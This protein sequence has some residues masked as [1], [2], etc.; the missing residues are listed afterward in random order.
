MANTIYSPRLNPIKYYKIDPGQLPQ[1]LSK[2]FDD[3]QFKNTIRDFEQP[4]DFYQPWIFEDSIRQQFISNFK[5]LTL[6]L[7]NCKGKVIYETPFQNMQQH[8]RLPDFYIRQSELDLGSLT[9]LEEGLYYFKI[10]ELDWISEPQE[11]LEYHPNTVYA[12]YSSSDNYYEGVIF[13]SPIVMSLRIPSILKYKSPGSVD[14]IY[15]DQNEAETML[16]SVPFR[17]WRFIVGGIGG[18]PP[19]FI[20][21]VARITGCDNLK[22]DGRQYTKA[23][24]A[25][26]EE[27]GL[28][29]YPM[30]GWAIDLRELL[31]RNSDVEEND[32][33]LLGK[34]SMMLIQDSKWFGLDDN[35][36]DFLEFVDGN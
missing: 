20:D 1:Y 33:T 4:V 16:H 18:V 24:G 32:I 7:L 22:L 6:Q 19:Y 21:K 8:F 36:N 2:H 25:A 5:P 27:S 11:I 23:Q 30:S 34:A 28:D 17:V 14:T 9:G 29:N 26:W 10:K 15:T 3:W 13:G 35:G 12:E 31:N